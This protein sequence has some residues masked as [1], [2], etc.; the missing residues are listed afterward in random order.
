MRTG[1][2]GHAPEEIPANAGDVEQSRNVEGNGRRRL[3]LFHTYEKTTLEDAFGARDT[4]AEA[5]I[6]ACGCV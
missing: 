6:A 4:L 5:R 3:P 2:A 1:Y